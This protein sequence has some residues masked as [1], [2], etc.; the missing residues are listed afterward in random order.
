MLRKVLVLLLIVGLGFLALRFLPKSLA[1]R[2][3]KLIGHKSTESAEKPVPQPAPEPVSASAAVKADFPSAF[4]PPPEA[5]KT[6]SHPKWD[7]AKEKLPPGMS[8]GK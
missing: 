1:E 2:L 4:P 6:P 7:P 3:G 8:G 5:G